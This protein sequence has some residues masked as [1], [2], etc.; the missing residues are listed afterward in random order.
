M[1]QVHWSNGTLFDLKAIRQKTKENNA[2]LIIDGSQSVGTYPFSVQEIEP[3][4]LVCAGYK[5][6]FG[7]YGGAFAY[8]GPYFDHGNPIEENWINRLDSEDFAGLTEYQDKYKPF[9]NRYTSGEAA[10]F[11]TVQMRIAALK[12]VLDWQPERIQEYCKGITQKMVKQLR[13][14]GC[15]I[16]NDEDRTHHMFGVGF[17]D[18]FDMNL[19]KQKFQEQKVY[20]SFRGNFLRISCHLFTTEE[21][22]EVLIKSIR[23][24]M[25]AS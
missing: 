22:F 13:N 25:E 2:L 15:V 11:I 19:L 21:D 4:A 9:A 20:V 18:G 23:S 24:C 12:Q 8:Y 7:P 1:G 10:S 3:D 6:L 17:P 16:E 5:W 14:L